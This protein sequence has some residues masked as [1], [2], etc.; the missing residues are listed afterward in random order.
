MSDFPS[1]DERRER[2]WGRTKRGNI[3]LRCDGCGREWVVRPAT[4]LPCAG[5]VCRQ[6]RRGQPCA[7]PALPEGLVSEW[8]ELPN[9]AV[10]G[11]RLAG[12]AGMTHA[13]LLM[14]WREA[15]AR[16]Q[17]ERARQAAERERRRA[18]EREIREAAAAER[19]RRYR[20]QRRLAQARHR[21]ILATSFRRAQ[22]KERGWTDGEIRRFLGEPEAWGRVRGSY[23][24]EVGFWAQERVLAAEASPEYQTFHARYQ[25]QRRKLSDAEKAARAMAREERA[26]RERILAHRRAQGY[27]W[28]AGAGE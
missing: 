7:L 19:D 8:L 11:Y 28:A 18:E 10:R 26:T 13:E 3:I 9:G 24:N 15:R 6:G 12:P 4:L 16:E 23:Q 17:A 27:A 1:P 5:V 20:E 21:E 22:L 14:G 2:G 25:A